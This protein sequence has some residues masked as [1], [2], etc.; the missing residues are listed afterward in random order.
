MSQ[1]FASGGQSGLP[2]SDFNLHLSFSI[3][4]LEFYLQIILFLFYL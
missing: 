2:Y 1:L 4:Y 3:Y